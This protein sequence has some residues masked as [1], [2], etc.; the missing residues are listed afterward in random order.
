MAI[1]GD[2]IETEGLQN[3]SQGADALVSEVVNKSFV[4]DA[5]CAL[6]RLGNDDEVQI[7]LAF[8]TPIAAIFGGELIVG[9]DGTSV[10]VP[11]E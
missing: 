11:V 8:S 4:E 10:T 9:V 3:M 1:S 6:R 5:E 7:G 2:T